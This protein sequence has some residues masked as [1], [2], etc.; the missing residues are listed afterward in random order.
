MV[1][2]LKSSRL[3]AAEKSVAQ[4]K[5]LIFTII[6]YLAILAIFVNLNN[7]K[8]PLVGLIASAFFFVINAIF[9]GHAFLENEILFFRFTFGVLLL[10]MLLGFVGWL[11][12]II[13]NLDIIEFTLVL[14]ITTT[15]SSLLNRRMKH[16]SASQ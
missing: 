11:I 3:D 7:I 10:V 13:Y 12:M 8:S 15:L 16:K 6:S 5:K 9:L 4:N 2:E 14:V 1:N